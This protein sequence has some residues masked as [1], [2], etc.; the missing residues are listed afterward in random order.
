ML[1]RH[2]C[3]GQRFA[4]LLQRNPDL[5]ALLCCLQARVVLPDAPDLAGI[6][7]DDEAEFGGRLQPQQAAV[8]GVPTAPAASPV[9]GKDSVAGQK[10]GTNTGLGPVAGCETCSRSGWWC[11]ARSQWQAGDRA[12]CRGF[13]CGGLRCLQKL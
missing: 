4:M 3:G 11:L 9:P 1:L 8:P 12:G 13:L 7:E 2:R 10:Q 6:E 5:I